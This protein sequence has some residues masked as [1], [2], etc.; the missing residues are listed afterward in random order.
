MIPCNPFFAAGA[1][2]TTNSTS[3]SLLPGII[4]YSYF[5]VFVAIAAVTVML[6]VVDWVKNINR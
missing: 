2:T 3:T 6:V 5:E 4:P 1:T